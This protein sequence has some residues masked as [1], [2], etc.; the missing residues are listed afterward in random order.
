MKSVAK[1]T[2]PHRAIVFVTVVC[3]SLLGLQAWGAWA[4]YG[5]QMA[6][7]SVA[8][9]NMRRALVQH[10]E[11]TFRAADVVLDDTVERLR[12]D[13]TSPAALQR[14][15][16][17]FESHYAR[18]RQINGI[19]VYDRGGRWIAT[20]MDQLPLNVN[21]SD[22]EYFKFHLTHADLGSHIGDPVVS[23]ST[24]RWVIPVSRRYDDAGGRFAGVVLI[25]IEMDFFTNF[26]ETFDIGRGGV[27]LFTLDKGTLLTRLPFDP[28]AVGR[29]LSSGVVLTALRQNGPGTAMLKSKIDGI[30]R[31]YSFGH[32]QGY[33]L[34]VAAALSK[35]EIDDGWL[36]DTYKSTAIV[37]CLITMLSIAGFRLVKQISVREKAESTLLL[38][39]E[40]LL[41]ANTSLELLSLKDQLTSLGN[42][43]QFDL[44]LS[45]EIQ[46]AVIY[47]TSVALIMIDVDYFKSF[48]DTY[49]HLA[50]D[51]CLRRIAQAIQHAQ[52]R[53]L[54]ISTRYGGEEFAVVLPN[55]DAKGAYIAAERIRTEIESIAIPHTGNPNGFVTVSLGIAAVMPRTEI[56][57]AMTLIADADGA[58]YAAKSSGRN[59][60]YPLTKLE[61]N[62]N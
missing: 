24:K 43:R 48:N 3:V 59:R 16:A 14:L 27:V 62:L 34:V 52:I 13:G 35:D 6:E 25:M 39:K 11:D 23:R 53:T 26:Y 19:L 51:A 46:R 37:F 12:I 50:G 7:A 44:S 55:T 29:D 57:G 31:L 56:N 42:R 9:D 54:D 58:L 2:T 41:N 17:M 33:P 61:N 60:V 20:S 5:R 10:A 47:Q 32:T 28:Q 40:K 38:T 49:G 21:N 15:H 22:R 8:T 1:I 45:T 4:A 36:A 18:L 30:V